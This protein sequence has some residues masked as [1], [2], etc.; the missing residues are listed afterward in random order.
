[1]ILHNMH[2]NKLDIWVVRRED[3]TGFQMLTQ[4]AK[5]WAIEWGNMSDPE[6]AN[7]MLWVPTPTAGSIIMDLA[8]TNMHVLLDNVNEEKS[9][10]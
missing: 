5:T 10:A 8:K 4:R 2:H 6:E 1:V 9:D 7:A 3:V